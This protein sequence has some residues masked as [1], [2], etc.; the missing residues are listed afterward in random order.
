MYQTSFE[1][2]SGEFKMG[3][4]DRQE[5]KKRQNKPRSADTRTAFGDWKGFVACELNEAQKAQVKLLFD[6]PDHL[7]TV[8][9]DLVGA[10]YKL[11]ISQDDYNGTFNV[12][13]TSRGT[14]D[15]NAGLTL[16]GRGGS[17]LGALAAFVYKHET[18]LEGDW[19]S[20]GTQGRREVDEGFV[21]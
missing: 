10:S 8:V 20:A 6:K 5:P 16:T 2:I 14:K 15:I 17:V 1:S 21:G 19:T 7:W 18:V 9:W 4:N 13:M 3:M 11:T 12:S